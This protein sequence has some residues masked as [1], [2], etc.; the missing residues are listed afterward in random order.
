[1]KQMTEQYIKN[2]I[3]KI[4]PTI[5]GYN[6]R[7]P[8]RV[9]HHPWVYADLSD[10]FNDKLLL[11]ARVMLFTRLEEDT[12][13]PFREFCQQIADIVEEEAIRDVAAFERRF[14]IQVHENQRE[15]CAEVL[16]EGTFADAF[17]IVNFD[18]YQQTY[19]AEQFIFKTQTGRYVDAIWARQ[20][21]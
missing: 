7:Q 6:Q 5:D 15:H 12:R 20:S 2:E 3:T 9:E 10:G 19:P 18:L 4:L 1:M 11:L 21:D 8:Y 14:T 13:I 17:L 16:H